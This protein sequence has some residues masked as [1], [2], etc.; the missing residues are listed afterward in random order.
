MRNSLA[1]CNLLALPV[2]AA[3]VAGCEREERQFRLDP[4][5]EAAF[6]NVALMPNGIVA[7]RRKS[8]LHSTGPTRLTPIISARGNGCMPGSAA[9][10]AMP[11][12]RAAGPAFLDGWWYYGPEMVSIFSSIRDGRPH[13][14]PAFR[15]G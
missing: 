2:V 9:G 11:T 7:H 15:T 12:A 4:P 8:M 13:G 6:D 10:I 3:V 1:L 14:M 5:I